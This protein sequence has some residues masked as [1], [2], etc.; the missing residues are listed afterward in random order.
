MEWVT[1]LFNIEYIL[2][3]F[4]I[5]FFITNIIK[6]QFKKELNRTQKTYLTFFIATIIAFIYYI[7]NYATWPV[8]VINYCVLT[9]FYELFFKQ[10]INFLTSY[11]GK[12]NEQRTENNN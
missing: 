7:L 9:S 8:L 6:A 12:S 11:L 1:S 5:T 10:I 4:A 3:V 2:L